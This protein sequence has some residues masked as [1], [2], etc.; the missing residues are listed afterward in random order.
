MLSV[1]EIKNQ[2]ID[3]EVEGKKMFNRKKKMKI[4]K[5]LSNISLESVEVELLNDFITYW[6]ARQSPHFHSA[7]L[8]EE[9][10]YRDSNNWL[11]L[12]EANHK[13]RQLYGEELAQ[14]LIKVIE[15]ND[16]TKEV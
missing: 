14:S 1:T 9:R 13:F 2:V 10:K 3:N 8:I 4:E 12:I 6:R 7:M 15:E 16:P 11:K 5:K